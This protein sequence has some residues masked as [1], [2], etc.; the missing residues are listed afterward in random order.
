MEAKCC[1][2]LRLCRALLIFR[3]PF[4]FEHI[5]RGLHVQEHQNFE[6]PVGPR[7]ATLTLLTAG[8]WGAT[9]VAVKYSLD[10]LPPIAVSGIR[11]ALAA[12]F[13]VFWCGIEGS[14]LRLRRHEVV[15]SL[16]M[17]V[18]LF[19]QIALFTV[20]INESS[21]SH[22]TVLINTYVFWVAGIEHF[23]TRTLRLSPVKIMG[24]T[25]AAAGGLL[26]LAGDS[27]AADQAAV[28]TSTLHGDAI[29]LASALVLGIKTIYT[30]QAARS[31]EP[32]KLIL[33]H[34]VVGVVLFA[35][36]MPHLRTYRSRTS[37]CA[38]CS[39]CFIRE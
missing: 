2:S 23:V 11:F 21:S 14:G 18:L 31:V 16:V 37:M 30:K 12:V 1:L 15:P 27:G 9:P 10:K 26:V 25:L 33:W 17:G 36:W 6:E 28:D 3:S 29:M 39:G 35:A 32:G 34:D 4:Q 19:V 24:L 8:L 5:N 38:C 13:M 22:S 20:A 7:A